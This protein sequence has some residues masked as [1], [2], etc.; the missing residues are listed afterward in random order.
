MYGNLFVG[1]KFPPIEGGVELRYGIEKD[2]K[3]LVILLLFPVLRFWI[4]HELLEVRIGC[5]QDS[6]TRSYELQ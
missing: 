1:A 5:N 4:D 2:L 3:A 6:L